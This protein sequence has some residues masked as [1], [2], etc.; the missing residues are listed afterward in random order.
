MVRQEQ[1]E[2]FLFP[3]IGDRN[4]PGGTGG[5]ITEGRR[6]ADAEMV[7]VPLLGGT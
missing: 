4:T 5:F 7:N 3:N 6:A 2:A 1:G